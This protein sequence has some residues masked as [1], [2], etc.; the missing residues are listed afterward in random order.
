M[1]R[2]LTFVLLVCSSV[3]AAVTL[4]RGS[5]VQQ[6]TQYPGQPTQG[7]VW[8]QNHGSAEAV[9]V[10]VEGMAKEAQP[11]RVQL[12][13]T[14]PA[15]TVRDGSITVRAMRQAWEYDVITVTSGQVPTTMLNAAGAEGWESTGIALPVQNG[16][17]LVMKRPRQ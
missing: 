5:G 9:P 10:S 4:L 6:T 3:V 15:I 13:G 2:T 1:T 12:S 11:L 16:V 14:L 8:I 7:S 17:A